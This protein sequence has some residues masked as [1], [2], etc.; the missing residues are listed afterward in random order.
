M[1]SRPVLIVGTRLRLPSGRVVV[2]LSTADDEAVCQYA[3]RVRGEVV[4]SLRW[5]QV[6]CT[7]C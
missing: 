1:M 5:L 7:V 2:I 3:E 6:H 4:F